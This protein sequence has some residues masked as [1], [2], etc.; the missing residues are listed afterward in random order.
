MSHFQLSN[1][2]VFIIFNCKT[3]NLVWEWHLRSQLYHKRKTH[4]KALRK[5]QP[6]IESCAFL[7]DQKNCASLFTIG[8]A[9]WE[10][11]STRWWWLLKNK[12]GRES[13]L[14]RKITWKPCNSV[15]TRGS[16]SWQTWRAH[17][18]ER[19][20]LFQQALSSSLLKYYLTSKEPVSNCALPLT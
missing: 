16:R 18:A 5:K 7:Q 19:N 2:H 4:S 12:S 9:S 8:T 15:R 3:Q 6:P 14:I 11:Q 1:Q 20:K 10:M 17:K 13:V